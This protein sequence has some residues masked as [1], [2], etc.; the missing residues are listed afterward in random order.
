MTQRIDARL[1]SGIFRIDV[2]RIL[3]RSHAIRRQPAGHPDLPI[4]WPPSSTANYTVPNGNPF[5]KV[6]G[7]VLEEY[8]AL[9]FRQPYRFSR[10]PVTGAFW[11]GES[12]QS[13][14][15][16]IDILQAG[17]NYG[18]AF[19]EGTVAGPKAAPATVI[20]TLK[21]PPLGIWP[22]SGWLHH[23][24]LCLSRNRA[25]ERTD[26]QIHFRGQCLGPHLCGEGER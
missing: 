9:G 21:E 12:G 5:V 6:D 2:D 17:A 8:Y 4:G 11:V 7:S 15:E 13:T 1:H 24:R 14:R 22:G 26:R 3:S 16:E 25:R 10:G 18:W 20:G 19:R 23:W